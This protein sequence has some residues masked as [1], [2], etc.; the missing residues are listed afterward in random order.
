MN[1]NNKNSHKT[2]ES[3]FQMPV[4]L[5]I[6]GRSSTI[7]NVFVNSIIP[8]IPPSKEEICTA[9]EILDLDPIM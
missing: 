9:L 8:V 5:P 2:E 3:P 7:T 4:A 1:L 6:T